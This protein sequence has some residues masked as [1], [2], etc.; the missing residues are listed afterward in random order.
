MG[1]SWAFITLAK[2]RKSAEAL[3]L[4]S[5]NAIRWFYSASTG[6]YL[7]DWFKDRTT[8]CAARKQW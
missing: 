2:I 3:L 5:H 8:L 7:G 6:F 1:M 4:F